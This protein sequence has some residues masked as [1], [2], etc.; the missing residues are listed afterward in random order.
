MNGGSNRAPRAALL[1]RLKEITGAAGFIDEPDLLAA[2]ETDA[3]G[4]FGGRASCVVRPGSP[5]DVAA[6]LA[7][8]HEAE[9]PLVVQGGNTGLAGG[10]VPQDGEIVLSL[11]RMNAVEAPAPYGTSLVAEAG[12]TLAAVQ[13]AAR[14]A[15]MEFALD[16]P[17]RD[18]ATVGGAISTNAAGPIALR[19]GAMRSQL[20][21]LEAVRA[22]GRLLSRMVPV[23]KDNAGYDWPAL[24][25]GSEGT[26]AVVVRARLKLRTPAAARDAF[27][28]GLS[29]ASEALDV[30]RQIHR[31][32]GDRLEALDFVD[33]IGLSYVQHHRRLRD[34]LPREHGV[35]IVGTALTP[36][37]ADQPA[38]ELLVESLDDI[39]DDAIVAASST[40]DRHALWAYREGVNES[41]RAWGPVHKFDVSL[42]LDRLA[43][44]AEILPP[45]V[46]AVAPTA[47]VQ[48]YGH[49]L[50]GNVHV[51][52]VGVGAD[53]TAFDAV[54]FDT[55]AALGGS[56]D[57][58]HGVG[59]AKTAF[60]GRTRSAEEL[61]LMRELRATFDP[62]GIL[63]RG[64]VF[65]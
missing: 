3:T 1:R 8:C 62:R 63:G 47:I 59:L 5:P 41:L 35:Y 17:A 26:L 20:A 19:W 57:A 40:G 60:L 23:A 33:R 46:R 18:S 56:I 16:F 49:L 58:E 42:P 52:V 27:L 25:T 37:A 44:F 65:G 64:R 13:A 54:V 36:F 2:Y 38:L 12:A 10:G 6:V 48:L 4:R 11:G 29:D 9:A 15:G 39:P 32:L 31:V 7:V 28:I 22:D 14:T 34:P 53:D 21:G 55:V 45:A 43:E 50:D 51:N 61:A 30:A 24:V